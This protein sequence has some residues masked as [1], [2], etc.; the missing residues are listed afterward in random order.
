[1]KY[2]KDIY[3]KTGTLH[4]A[5]L[6]TGNKE[7][8][9]PSLFDFFE[10]TLKIKT[11]G[12]P[13]F[14]YRE[15]NSFG[16]TDSREV[17]NMASKKVFSGNLK[18]FVVS[19]FSITHEA[20]NSLLK[21]FEEPTKTTHFFIITPTESVLLPTLRSRLFFT[22]SV[23]YE[24]TTSV[25]TEDFLKAQKSKRIK[26]LQEIIENKDKAQASR[27]LGDLEKRLRKVVNLKTADA[28]TITAFKEIQKAR[29]YLNDRS[30]SVK[31]L[32]EH[33][34]LVTPIIQ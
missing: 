6:F 16:I 28:A 30:P 20:Q 18:I 19:F 7:S 9:V 13:D 21:L 32:L 5:Y 25:L 10:N 22:P 8:I 31:M 15:F 33:I 14:Y 1:M 3:N 26:L 12:N 29:Q 23:T 17:Q 24:D 2:L 4:H 11:K 27:F 34:S